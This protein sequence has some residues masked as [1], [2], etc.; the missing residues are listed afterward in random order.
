M[1][2]FKVWCEGFDQDETDAEIF[3]ANNHEHAVVLW[4]NVYDNNYVWRIC[5]D[6]AIDV[7]VKLCDAGA[8]ALL[9]TVTG[10]TIPIYTVSP[11]NEQK[12]SS[13]ESS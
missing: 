1:S 13:C 9:K 3:S 4:A 5:D 2:K 11:S 7:Y 6:N 12:E 10:Y 8:T